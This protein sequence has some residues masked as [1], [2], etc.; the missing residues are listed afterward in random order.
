[1]PAERASSAT[2][3]WADDKRHG[4]GIM[5]Y[6]NSE[7]EVA[8][9]YDGDWV[10]VPPIR[11]DWFLRVFLTVAW[12]DSGPNAGRRLGALCRSETLFTGS[13]CARNAGRYWYEDGSCYEGTWVN[14]M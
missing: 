4:R 9:K 5:V 8:E 12:L 1:M 7:G 6:V 3:E 10:E 11:T 2:G 13:W 14:S